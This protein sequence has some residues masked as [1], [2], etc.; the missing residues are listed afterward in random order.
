M[1]PSFRLGVEAGVDPSPS[2]NASSV[3]ELVASDVV[4]S[5]IA[6]AGPSA[7]S[8]ASAKDPYRAAR[9]LISR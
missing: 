8:M 6:D 1:R 4:V 9:P 3:V 5:P 2:P 7:A